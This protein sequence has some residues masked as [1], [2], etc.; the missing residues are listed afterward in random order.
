LLYHQELLLTN[1]D[2]LRMAVSAKRF[3]N[4]WLLTPVCVCVTNSL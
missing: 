4:L 3:G 1:Q 2:G